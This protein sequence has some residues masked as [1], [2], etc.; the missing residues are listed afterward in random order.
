MIANHS[1]LFLLALYVLCIGGGEEEEE[2]EENK[3]GITQFVS[4]EWHRERHRRVPDRMLISTFCLRQQA[5]ALRGEQ[6]IAS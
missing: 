1:F 2:E 4:R 6:T 3:P 5:T